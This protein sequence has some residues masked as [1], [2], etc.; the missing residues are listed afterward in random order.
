MSDGH[1]PTEV[2]ADSDVTLEVTAGYT[3]SSPSAIELGTAAPGDTATGNNT[4]GSLV[5]NDPDGYTVTGVDAN[6]E[7]TKGKML[8]IGTGSLAAPQ[9]I[10]TNKLKMGDSG[11]VPNDADTA[12]TF[13]DTSGITNEVVSLYVSQTVAYADAVQS[14]Y[15]ITITYTV[16]EKT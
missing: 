15:T 14:G 13:V 12:F 1:F 16:T 7:V 6:T 3:F 4:D 10:L 5:G 11:A 9:Y 2:S 8:I